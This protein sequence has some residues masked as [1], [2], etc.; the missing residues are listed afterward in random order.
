[1]RDKTIRTIGA[2]VVLSG[3]A[4]VAMMQIGTGGDPSAIAFVSEDLDPAS[5]AA[6]IPA[7]FEHVATTEPAPFVYRVGVLAGVTT[8]NFWAFYGGEA[9]VWNAYILGPTKPA[10][11][12]LDPVD[13][14]L[15]PELA[16]SEVSPSLTSDGWRVEVPLS[17]SLSWSDGEPVT[18]HDIVFTF[19]TSRA[20]GLE[21]S[22]SEAFPTTIGSMHADS[23]YELR[24]EFTERP[25]LGVWPYGPGLAPVMAAHIWQPL[26]ED[27][28]MAELFALAGSHDVGGG[29]LALATIGETLVTSTANPGYPF[30]SVPDA[31]E[32]HIYEDEDAAL[33]ALGEGQIDSILTPNGLTEDQ[34]KKVASNPSIVVERNPANG[35]RY[36]GFNLNREPMSDLA[37][38]AALA[39][40]L[41]REGLAASISA[42]GSVAHSFV[43]N[44]NTRWFDPEAAG[45]NAERYSGNLTTRLESALDGLREAGY[46]WSTVPA[47]DADGG[48]AT[49]AGLKIRGLAPAPLTILTPGDAYD[50]TRPLYTAQIAETLGWL[51]FDV[52]PV[53]TDFDSVV[54]LVFTPGEDGLLHYDMYLLGWSLGNPALPGYYRTL[55]STEGLMNNTGYS[56]AGFA[57]QLEAY[58]GSYSFEDARQ[59]LWTME[60]TLS[61]D[62]PYLLLYRSEITEVYRSDRIAFDFASGLGGIQGR[63]GGIGD[64]RPAS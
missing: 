17:D 63:L 6:D 45:A 40:L 31:V 33:F 44:S 18:A 64:V 28:D 29:P 11:Y 61:A 59:A 1:M 37:F 10:L 12:S 15:A 39:L 21:G 60:S 26:V 52:R 7:T 43:S 23:D 35:V 47:V 22:W 20:L 58:E 54:D 30:G 46:T 48:I 56:S 34:L 53:E 19:D 49:G 2:T 14:S 50:P 8:D 55:F 9:S 13:G 27:V 5:G 3:I 57:Q 25:N 32:Y 42:G 24:I 36:L 38:R 51:G 16:V 41:D 62:L 4:V